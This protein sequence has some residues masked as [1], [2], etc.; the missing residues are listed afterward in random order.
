MTEPLKTTVLISGGGS[1]LQALIDARDSG[2]LNVDITHVISNV[3]DAGGLDRAER[4]GI[5]SSVLPH[6]DFDSRDAFDRALALLI[7]ASAPDLVVL[8]GFM[9]IIGAPVLEP[10]QGRLI[11]LHPSLLPLYRGTET[12]RRAIESGDRQHGASIHFVTAQLDGGPVISQVTIPIETQDSPDTLAARL[13]PEEH[14]L[15]VATVELFI[16]HRVECA[17]D[18]V[19]VDGLTLVQPLQLQADGRLDP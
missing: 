19:L 10:F 8:A 11:N 15:I 4:A 9:R 12:Y 5:S 17:D 3:A 7:A 6:G 14:A 1:N 2:R 16:R 18:V 13:S